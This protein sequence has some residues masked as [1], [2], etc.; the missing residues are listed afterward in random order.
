MPSFGRKVKPFAP[1]R[2]F[3]ACKRSINGVQGVIS[4][5]LPDHPRPQFHLSLL[6]ALALMGKW[7]HLATKVGTS[8]G[9]GKHWQYTPTRHTSIRY[10]SSCHTLVKM[11]ASIFFTA[12]VA[13]VVPFGYGVV[14]KH[15]TLM[16]NTQH[17]FFDI[18]SSLSAVPVNFFGLCR[19]LAQTRLTL[20]S[21][22]NPLTP[23]DL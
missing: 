20:S 4:A 5:K 23:N 9:R 22:V 11:G 3:G 1:C 18:D 7:R 21:R 19:K 16:Q 2:R 6:G 12:A 17:C 13:N 14:F 10:S 15:R 8:K